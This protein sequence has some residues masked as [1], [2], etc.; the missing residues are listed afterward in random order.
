MFS[1]ETHYV[2]WVIRSFLAIY[3]TLSS[4]GEGKDKKFDTWDNREI[5]CKSRINISSVRRKNTEASL[6]YRSAE[7]FPSLEFQSLCNYSSGTC[8]FLFSSLIL[9]DEGF[10][11]ILHDTQSMFQD[12]GSQPDL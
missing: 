3:T 1:Y 9:H 11:M 8:I 5:L 12:T 7:T 6:G 10:H 4:L 2:T